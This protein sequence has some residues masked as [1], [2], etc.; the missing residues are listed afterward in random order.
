MTEN[1]DFQQPVK[2]GA[3]EQE[4]LKQQ[5]REA[6]EP[7]DVTEAADNKDGKNLGDLNGRASSKRKDLRQHAPRRAKRGA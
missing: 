7:K 1:Q 4:L 5:G 6:P 3:H 2:I